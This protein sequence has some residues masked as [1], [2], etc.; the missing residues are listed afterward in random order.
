MVERAPGFKQGDRPVSI[1]LAEFEDCFDEHQWFHYQAM[2][3]NAK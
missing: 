2:A 1:D 3:D